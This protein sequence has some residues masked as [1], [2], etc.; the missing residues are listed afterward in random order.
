MRRYIGEIVDINPTWERSKLIW[1]TQ[2]SDS[3]YVSSPSF[4][5]EFDGW[6]Y[7]GIVEY[8][9]HT[10]EQYEDWILDDNTIFND[11]NPGKFEFD[12]LVDFRSPNNLVES[13]NI[14]YKTIYYKLDYDKVM[15]GYLGKWC[16]YEYELEFMKVWNRDMKLKGLLK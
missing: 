9:L 13:P 11:M 6:L 5:F 15:S 3:D 16:E 4:W 14:P 12:Y 1:I 10:F 8:K 7:Y 2:D